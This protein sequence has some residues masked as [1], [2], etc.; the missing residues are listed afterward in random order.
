MTMLNADGSFAM[1]SGLRI[2]TEIVKA[3]RAATPSPPS[4][5]GI[6]LNH[7]TQIEHLCREIRRDLTI[8]GGI[9]I[10]C[11]AQDL[12]HR[13]DAIGKLYN[14]FAREIDERNNK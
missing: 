9:F 10:G 11:R 7:L 1:P 4:D 12:A 6:V 3:V 2:P 13:A 8:S 14:S 5:A